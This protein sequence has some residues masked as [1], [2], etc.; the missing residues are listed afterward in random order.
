MASSQ[1]VLGT[2]LKNRFVS[3]K[4]DRVSRSD[5]KN[6][7]PVKVGIPEELELLFSLKTSH[8]TNFMLV[9][10]NCTLEDRIIG[11]MTCFLILQPHY[12]KLVS[13]NCRLRVS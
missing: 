9:E 11:K 1:S 3:P 8:F 4:N 10:N 13:V 7:F 12:G 6:H 2:F 5:Y